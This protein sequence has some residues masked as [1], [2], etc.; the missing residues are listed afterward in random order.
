[1]RNKWTVLTHSSSTCALLDGGWFSA[2]FP[3]SPSCVLIGVT[4]NTV[5]LLQVSA[6]ASLPWVFVSGEDMVVVVVD[7]HNYD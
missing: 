3:I 4:Q 7:K 2:K 6:S 5:H 1:M